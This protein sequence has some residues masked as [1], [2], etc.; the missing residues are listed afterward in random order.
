MNGWTI[1]TGTIVITNDSSIK[2][3]LIN[4][5]GTVTY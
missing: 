2:N 5:K 1:N 4:E 3:I